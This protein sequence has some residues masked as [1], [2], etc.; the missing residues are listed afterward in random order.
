M[1][2]TNNKQSKMKQ[3]IRKL[4]NL[5]SI[6]VTRSQLG[7]RLGQ[8]FDGDRDLYS[9]CGYPTV[10]SFEEYKG[11]YDRDPLAKRIVN[12]YPAA[13]WTVEPDV[14]E[15]DKAVET[16]FEKD[17]AA[18]TEEMD[19]CHYFERVDKAAGIGRY[20]VLFLGFDDGKDPKEPVKNGKLMYLQVYTEGS[21][22]I[23][24]VETD[25]KSPRYTQPTMYRI[26]PTAVSENVARG[27]VTTITTPGAAIPFDVH[28]TRI[29]HVA[30]N[31][32]DNDIYGTPRLEC[33][34]NRLQDIETTCGGSAEMFW[35]AGYPGLQ[36]VTPPDTQVADESELEDEIESY[37]HG[38]SR[39]MRLQNMEAKAVPGGGISSPDGFFNMYLASVSAATGIPVRIL[40]GSERGELA[41]S[42]D[43]RGWHDRIK[44][45]RKSFATSGILKPF[46]DRMIEVGALSDPGEYKTDWPPIEELNENEKMDIA[47][48]K[49][50]AIVDYVNGG[51]DALLTP[52]Q[53]L[54]EVLG[55]TP[56]EAE[57]I[58]AD[59]E[60]YQEENLPSQEEAVPPPAA[61]GE[62]A[63]GGE[64]DDS[65]PVATPTGAQSIPTPAQ[66]RR[67]AMKNQA[68]DPDGVWR[69]INGRA[70][71]IKEGQSVEEAMKERNT[72][73]AKDRERNSDVAADLKSFAKDAKKASKKVEDVKQ[74]IEEV[75]GEHK[76]VQ[77]AVAKEGEKI[78]GELKGKLS[79]VQARKATLEVKYEEATRRMA[80]LKARL[81]ELKG[82]KKPRRNESVEDVQKKIDELQAEMDAIKA[83][84]KK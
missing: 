3:L 6:T 69:T 55:Y 28:Y 72:P 64:A 26:T 44:E 70:I 66:G 8:S 35:R 57:D 32:L 61:P 16:A 74:K 37:V 18:L 2:R 7:Q 33:V 47:N 21:C 78:V 83:E 31:V 19:L 13:T 62:P 81:D 14:Y 51:A 82:M 15:T 25:R 41:S 77:G 1:M 48:K 38:L 68:E 56:K 73:D 80:E 63:G 36:F 39:Y 5:A 17:W 71:F 79:E 45:R 58:L 75:K 42:Q 23:I 50:K 24:T 52:E 12:A 11:R 84:L 29:I 76:V 22:Q 40:V 65:S 54:M 10:L 4:N 49:V 34:W 59:L 30:D 53:F 67:M 43:E 20:G 27:S 46:I 9:I 60:K